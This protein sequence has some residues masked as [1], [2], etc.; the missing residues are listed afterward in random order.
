MYCDVDTVEN[1][2]AV[3]LPGL[4]RNPAAILTAQFIGSCAVTLLG[5]ILL[6]GMVLKHHTTPHITLAKTDRR[7]HTTQLCLYHHMQKIRNAQ[8]TPQ[9]NF[10]VEFWMQQCGCRAGQL[11]PSHVERADLHQLCTEQDC[12]RTLNINYLQAA[13]SSGC[14]MEPQVHFKH[15]A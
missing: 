12:P 6:L 11:S 9:L 10:H 7:T 8:M 1:P 14:Y 15:N 3:G 4:E 13:A 2:Q 5:D